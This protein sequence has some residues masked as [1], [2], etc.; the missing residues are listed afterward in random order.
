MEEGFAASTAFGGAGYAAK[1]DPEPGSAV[2]A[3]PENDWS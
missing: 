2:V 3:A 1:T